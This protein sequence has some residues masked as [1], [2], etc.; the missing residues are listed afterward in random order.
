ME[1]EQLVINADFNFKKLSDFQE[2][3]KNKGINN[4]EILSVAIGRSRSVKGI[5]VG[6]STSADTGD[7]EDPSSQVVN[8]AIKRKTGRGIGVVAST[9]ADTGDAG[10][11]SSKSFQ[12]TVAEI[13]HAQQRK[14]KKELNKSHEEISSFFEYALPENIVTMDGNGLLRVNIDTFEDF[15]YR[16]DRPPMKSADKMLRYTNSLK[17]KLQERP[18]F[19]SHPNAAH[20]L[21]SIDRVSFN[22]YCL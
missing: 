22:F 7:A 10:D 13:S 2:V 1:L 18:N 6:P 16:Q 8:S 17:E 12:L 20:Y 4:R 5:G 11:P 19:A 9:S 21:S 14:E 3:W 15:I